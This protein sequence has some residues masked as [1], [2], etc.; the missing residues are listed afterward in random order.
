M[1]VDMLESMQ[2]KVARTLHIPSF[3][4]LSFVDSRQLDERDFMLDKECHFHSCPSYLF[5]C[6][7]QDA[8][9]GVVIVTDTNYTM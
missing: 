4:T 1:D 5:A 9:C 2:I 8:Q 6:H 7:G 3:W